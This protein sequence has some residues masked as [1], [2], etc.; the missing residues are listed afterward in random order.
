MISYK[1]FRNK[2]ILVTGASGLLG[3]TLIRTLLDSNRKEKL[4][5]HITALV[6]NR[7]RALQRFAG[8]DGRKDFSLLTGDVCQAEVFE[9]QTWDYIVHGAS[10]AHPKA[11]AT[12]P[13]ETMKANLLGTMNLLEYAVKQ[14]SVNEVKK[15]LFLSSGEIYG[16]AVMPDEK[17]W[18]EECAGLVNSMRPRACYPESKRA[19]EAL[20]VSYYQEYEIST[21]V[22][23]LSY[24]YGEEV[25]AD[26]TRADVQFLKNAL[27]GEDIVMKSEGTQMRSYCYVE[28]AVNALI[29][30]LLKGK[31]G[32]AYNVANH[33]S[34]ATIKEYATM[35]ADIFQV[36]LKMELPDTIEKSGYSQMKKE[37]LNAEKLYGLGWNPRYNLNAGMEKMKRGKKHLTVS[38]AE[39]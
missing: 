37:V 12:Q 30:L 5:L 21:V 3:F 15:L 2:R 24:I 35:L 31:A 13:V 29:L 9:G 17:G 28:D 33:A 34:V 36:G 10:N 6:R 23:R 4:D 14:K 38:Q 27:A 11:F 7:E 22:A 1:S 32:E 18:R 39:S 26:N 16:E 19:A 8:Y 20:C 25:L